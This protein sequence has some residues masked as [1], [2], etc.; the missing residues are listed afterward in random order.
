VLPAVAIEAT[1]LETG[2]SRGAATNHAG[3]YLL[4]G[5]QAGKYEVS[6]SRSGFTTAKRTGVILRVSDEIRIDLSLAL[7]GAKESVIVTESAPLV[8]TESGAVSTVVN[9]QA[10]QELPSDGRQLQN[11]ALIVP[12]VSAGWN[13]STAANRYGKARE[14]TEGP[15]T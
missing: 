10:I 1:N 7:G 15:S 14:N 11:L 12:G 2:L 4:S 3:V 8:Q 5:L 6:A 13:L 9:Q